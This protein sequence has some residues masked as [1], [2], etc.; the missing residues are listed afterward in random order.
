MKNNRLNSTGT[1]FWVSTLGIAL[2]LTSLWAIQSPIDNTIQALDSL[3]AK[4]SADNERTRQQIARNDTIIA[5][6]EAQNAR[7]RELLKRIEK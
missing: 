1:Y 3:N 2:I 5:E 7:M 6:M 4:L